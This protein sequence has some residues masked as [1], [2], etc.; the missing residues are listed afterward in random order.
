MTNVKKYIITAVI[1]GS[2]AMASGLLIGATNLITKDPIKEN[3][4]NRI[5]KGIKEV[6]DMPNGYVIDNGEVEG[7][8]YIKHY[9]SIQ[10]DESTPSFAGLAF[11]TTGNNMYGKISL[12]VGFDVNKVYKGVAIVTNEQTFASTLVKN[13]IDP[14]NDP[15]N[16]D[17]TYDDKSDLSCGAT[18]GA[19][20]VQ[21][22]ILEV[23]DALPNY[24]NY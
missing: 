11:L 8:T 15:D 3:E 20:L 23:Q 4:I 1:L 22:M 10:A 6:F 2:I 14:I 24:L 18:Y 16:L 12:I 5:N 17:I 19:T 21:K 13:Y 7:Y 9:Y